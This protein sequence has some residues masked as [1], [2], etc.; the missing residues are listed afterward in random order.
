M[1]RSPTISTSSYCLQVIQHSLVLVPFSINPIAPSLQKRVPPLPTGT[2]LHIDPVSSLSK[3]TLGEGPVV[4]LFEGRW[5]GGGHGDAS[6]EGRRR[7]PDATVGI[8]FE[9]VDDGGQKTIR[10]LGR[11]LQ[12]VAHGLGKILLEIGEEIAADGL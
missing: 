2:T 3:E 12:A 4:D 1:F 6:L 11:G 8:L 7:M 10:Q 9:A 5:R